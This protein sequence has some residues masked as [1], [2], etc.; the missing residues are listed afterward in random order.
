MEI[1]WAREEDLSALGGHVSGRI[2]SAFVIIKDIPDRAEEM[3]RTMTDTSWINQLD[4]VSQKAF[5][6]TTKRTIEKLVKSFFDVANDQITTDFGEYMVSDSAQHVLKDQFNH[7]KLPLA[8]LLKEKVTGN[9]GFDFH[10]ET[11]T[12]LIAYGEAKYSGNS[13]PYAKALTQINEFIGDKKDDAELIILSKLVS[14]EATGNAVEGNKAYVAAFSINAAK[15][16]DI[17]GN[18]LGSEHVKTLLSFPEVYVIGI[19]VDAK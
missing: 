9:P 15:P 2:F 11:E 1:V 19:K 17:M 10:T 5:Q 8:E 3:I 7:S 12:K 13:S 14:S 16:E 18:V 4:I 6:S